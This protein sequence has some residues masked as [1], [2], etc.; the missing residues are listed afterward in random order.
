M[1]QFFAIL[2]DSY[3]EAVDG[4]V[5]YVMMALSALMI[6]I[7]ASMSYTPTTPD[8]A[9]GSIVKRF[10]LV[11]PDQGRSQVFTGSSDE[12]RASDVKPSGGG[13]SLRVELKAQPAGGTVT[14]EKG[15]RPVLDEG[16]SFRKT[17]ASWSKP[18]GKTGE[19]E[20]DDSKGKN[21]Q[22]GGGGRRRVQF[23]EMSATPAEQKAVTDSQ[24][25]TFIKSQFELHAG[26]NATVKR[27]TAGVSEPTYAFEVTTTGG[28]SVQGWPH[29]LKIFF[30][31]VTISR[32]A[33]LGMVL[34]IVEDQIING[35][36]SGLA[37]LISIIITSFFIPN[38]MRKGSIDLLVSKPIGRAQLLIYKF[39]GGLTFIFLLST[40]TIGGVWLAIAVRSGYWDPRFLVVI[41]VLTF[42]FAILYSVSTMV[43]V[44]TRSPI[45]AMIVTVGFAVFL[46]IVG[47]VKTMFD[48]FKARGMDDIPDWAFTLVDT[49]NNIL[50]RYK[51]LD[52]LTSKLIGEGALT[53][54]E[55]RLLG[56]AAIDYPSWSG[57]FGVSLIFIAIMM[58]LSCWRFS[59]RDY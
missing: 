46:Y 11:F 14:D 35:L 38:M 8:E 42:T 28:S 20:V 17:V 44:F 43:A 16:D 22:K 10:N 1:R 37:L 59:K 36:G 4:F 19:V 40:I 26:M 9:F 33:P 53:P 29:T 56:I 55:S 45:A 18:P 13:Y 24:M 30:G 58:A 32:D 15:T 52:K 48:G 47:T 12:Y 49:I 6:L 27:V 39:I 25:E 50:P 23:G 2:K 31:S 5:I 57:T 41:P 34:Y 21:G 7:V 54:G 3:R 51:D